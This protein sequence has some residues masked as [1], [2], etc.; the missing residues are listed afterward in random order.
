MDGEVSD[1]AQVVVHVLQAAQHLEAQGKQAVSGTSEPARHGPSGALGDA[2][3]ARACPYRMSSP[4]PGGPEGGAVLTGAGWGAVV[5]GPLE[6]QRSGERE[7]PQMTVSAAT[8]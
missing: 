6:G 2:R 3:R 1:Q 5:S 7:R 4:R 8:R